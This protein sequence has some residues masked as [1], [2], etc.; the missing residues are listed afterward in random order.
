MH[1]QNRTLTTHVGSLIRPPKLIAILEKLYAGEDVPDL[2][3]V[4]SSAVIDVVRQQKDC[5]IDIISDGE[6]SKCYTWS[7]YII[8]RLG[9]FERRFL[10]PGASF[11]TIR[12]KDYET[13]KDFYDKYEEMEGPA[14][15]GKSIKPSVLA[16]TGPLCYRDREV[17]TDIAR[18]KR[19]I[20]GV[21]VAGAFMPV[22]APASVAPSRVDEYYES[23]ED[24]LFALADELNKE[25]RAIVDAGFIL[26]VDDAFMAT[27]YDVIGDFDSYRDW[28]ELRVEALNRALD[29][30]PEEHS[31]YHLCWGSWNGPHSNDI[32]IKRIIDLVLKIKAGGYAIEMANPRHEHEWVVWEDVKL[33]DGKVLI[34]GVVSHCTNV[35]EHPELVAERIVRLA[36]LVGRENVIAGSDCGF[37]QGPFGQRVH[38]TIMWAKLRAITEGAM[39]A[40]QALW[41]K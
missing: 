33:P 38:P 17:K 26:Q 34:P 7:Q 31:R 19:A 24:F 11:T 1:S 15:L 6:F 25:Y 23:D 28:A 39:L 40:T 21:D 41:K 30:V 32:E 4:L 22:V 9:G 20:E 37:A 5:G 16:V 18:F 3:D 14:G 8:E 29:G 13:F 36:R 35:V 2:E 10:E 12:G 27:H